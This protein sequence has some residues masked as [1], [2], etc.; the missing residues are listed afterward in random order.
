[1]ANP[2]KYNTGSESRALN[3]GNWW[4]G[5]GDISKGPTASTGFW[6]GYDVPAGGYV[7]YLNK[8]SNGPSIYAPANDA[9]LI[10]LTNQIA[11]TSYTTVNECFTYFAGQD[12]KMVVNRNYENIVTDG[13]VLDEGD[14]TYQSL[15]DGKVAIAQIYNR[16]LTPQEI[17]QNYNALKGRYGL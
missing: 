5:T 16:A 14:L 7:V 2:I 15:L 4:I 8:A 13:L 9:E 6:N 17:L 12:D 3:K 10:S 11:N 1:M